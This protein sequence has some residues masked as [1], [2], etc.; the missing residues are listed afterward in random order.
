M[1]HTLSTYFG[2]SSHCDNRNLRRHDIV[3]WF[4]TTQTCTNYHT[5]YL[6]VFLSSLV[7]DF[8]KRVVPV[9]VVHLKN[10]FSCRRSRK[11]ISSLGVNHDTDV[12]LC[13]VH[14]AIASSQS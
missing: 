3:K 6:S 10:E 13:D 4:R 14:A 8:V 9:L 1:L 2:T 11:R 5:G 12:P 7:A